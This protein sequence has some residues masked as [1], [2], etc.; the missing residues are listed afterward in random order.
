MH[1]L[2]LGRITN[3]A[4]TACIYLRLT[5]YAMY[6]ICSV[7]KGTLK[8]AVLEHI[9]PAEST[10]YSFNGST[11]GLLL[12]SILFDQGT[13]IEINKHLAKTHRPEALVSIPLTQEMV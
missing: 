12:R 13:V 4:P 8:P 10:R 7:D 6:L 3:K 1:S 9:N 2:V 5:I 11:S